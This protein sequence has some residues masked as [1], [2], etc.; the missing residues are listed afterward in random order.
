[1]TKE[2]KFLLAAKDATNA[3][4]F[5]SVET[6]VKRGVNIHA[7]KRN[8]MEVDARCVNDSK[9]ASSLVIYVSV[10]SA[11]RTHAMNVT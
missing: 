4:L 2:S 3:K 1:M 10:S 6:V 9:L 7:A 5:L 11:A 8:V